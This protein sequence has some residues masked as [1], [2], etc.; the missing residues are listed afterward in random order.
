[1]HI[2]K[3]SLH[4]ADLPA[5][6]H[7]YTEVLG[8]PLHSR[9]AEAFSVRI[10]TSQLNFQQAPHHIPYHVAFN[11]PQ[12][13]IEAAK[14]WGS[15]RAPLI[16]MDSQDIY[17]FENWNAHSIYFCDAEGNILE[18]IAHHTLPNSSHA[19]FGP[20]AL[21]SVC[22]IGLAVPDVISA[23]RQMVQDYQVEVFRGQ[24]NNSFM[25]VGDPN[26]M[27]IV[28]KEGREWFPKTGIIAG[29]PPLT[30]WFSNHGRD[31]MHQA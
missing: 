28:V 21:L 14:A 27:L 24:E 30:V 15:A 5:Q 10:G 4:S 6:H 13:Q 29:H 8:L 7:F 11:I 1:M 22:E 18:C 16:A 19:P 25:S 3:L 9:S 20:A 2:Q 31:F 23:A 17:F 12:N 26:G